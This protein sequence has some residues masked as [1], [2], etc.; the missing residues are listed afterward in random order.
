MHTSM[1]VIHKW[2]RCVLPASARLTLG[3][4]EEP[5]QDSLWSMSNEEAL[6]RGWSSEGVQ[7]DYRAES[8]SSSQTLT[9]TERQDPT[10]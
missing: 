2:C 1:G 3:L 10:W 8:S 4:K 6:S 9:M 5:Q 7:E